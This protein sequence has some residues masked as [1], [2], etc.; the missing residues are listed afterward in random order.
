MYDLNEWVSAH[1]DEFVRDLKCLVSY[2]SISIF[3][4]G[5]YSMGEGCAKCLDCALEMG[6]HMGLET[7]N[8]DYYCGSMIL[9]GTG[10]GEIALV[11]HLDVVPPGDGW[12]Y[13]PFSP[14]E[15]DGWVIGRGACDNKGSVM[16]AIYALRYIK[17]QGI[18]L[19]FDVR[20]LM[21]CNEEDGMRDMEYFLKKHKAPDF[22][23]VI[24]GVMNLCYGEKGMLC[25]ELETG[26]QDS[27]IEDIKGGSAFNSVPDSAS[28]ILTGI[29][30]SLLLC[31]EARLRKEDLRWENLGMG[32]YRFDAKG[33]A[34]HAAFPDQGSVNAIQKLAS[35]LVKTNLPNTE[36]KRIL[37]FLAEAFADVYGEGLDIQSNDEI[38][39]K[40]THI[41]GMIRVAEGKIM[42][43]VNVRYAMCTDSE[44]LM[45]RMRKRCQKHGF[46]AVGYSDSKPFYVDLQSPFV[47]GILKVRD[48]FLVANGYDPEEIKPFTMGGGTHAR[49]LPNAVSIGPGIMNQGKSRF[50]SAHAADEAVCIDN[51]LEGIRFF[52]HLLLGIQKNELW[53]LIV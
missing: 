30:E 32:R 17:E 37:G 42:Q 36:A 33:M 12:N 25:A 2:P 52:V 46:E 16:A 18:T 45:E 21:G 29:E 48:E 22:S 31:E 28:V 15:I 53:K 7:E 8:D 26:F 4:D 51:L 11:G 47:A 13:V 1:Y 27:N 34:G 41:G 23:L 40:T 5:P 20:L 9:K 44:R 24:D 6:N 3:Q 49:K 19:P 10:Q 43:N 50:G 38:F 39:G 14:V 35:G